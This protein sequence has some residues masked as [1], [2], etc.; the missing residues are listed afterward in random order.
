MKQTDVEH[1]I[2]SNASEEFTTS[3]LEKM[4]KVKP[5]ARAALRSTIYRMV[6]QGYLIKVAPATFQRGPKFVK[7]LPSSTPVQPTTT[8]PQL[9]DLDATNL[10]LTETGQAIY[11]LLKKQDKKIADLNEELTYAVEQNAELEQ[12]IRKLQERLHEC[13]EQ[14]TQAGQGS[15]RFSL[16]ELQSHLNG[17]K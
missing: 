11:A 12:T 3:W 1:I 4:L 7:P 17:G 2:L 14:L 15:K 9:T 5:E 8:A 10:S 6:K 13:N 16:H